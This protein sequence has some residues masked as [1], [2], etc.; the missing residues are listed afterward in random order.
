MAS[1]GLVRR[2]KDMEDGRV[3]RVYITKEGQILRDKTQADFESGYKFKLLQAIEEFD[4][5]DKMKFEEMLKK[6]TRK[7]LDSE[8]LNYVESSTEKLSI[9]KNHNT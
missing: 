4:D 6:I 1:K 2:E 3:T 8:F 7:V 9:E 5:T